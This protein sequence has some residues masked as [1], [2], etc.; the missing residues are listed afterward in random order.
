MQPK[1]QAEQ[2]LFI[3]A[4]ALQGPPMPLAV[5]KTTTETL[6]TTVVLTDESAMMP[7]LK[8]SNFADVTVTA[9]ISQQ[10]DVTA[11]A[12]DLQGQ[13]DVM[14]WQEAGTVAIVIDKVIE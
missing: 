6:P 4:R 1:V 14:N 2:T 11:Q 3:F 7:Q 12:G 10:G 9:R 13:L 5:V 8:L